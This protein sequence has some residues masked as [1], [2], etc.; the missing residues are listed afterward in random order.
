MEVIV[1]EVGLRDGLQNEAPIPLSDKIVLARS[2][3]GTGLR[4]IE[5]TAFMR[6]DAI[7]ALADADQMWE[8]CSAIP[9]VEW[10]ALVAN[11][12]GTQRALQAGATHLEFVVSASETHNR[13][14]VRRSRSE[15]LAEL[16]VV[17]DHVHAVGGDVQAIIATSFGCPYE[18]DI[19]LDEVLRTAAAARAA[20]ADSLAF[21]D[22]TGVATP[23]RVHQLVD[24]VLVDHAD[25]PLLMHFHDTRGLGIAN[26]LAALE[27]GIAR[28]DASVGGLGGCP[29]APG[30]SGNVAT[31][32]VVHVLH[33]MGID[34]GI[35]LEAI[36]S[37]AVLAE[38]MIGRKLPS[39]VM[40]AGPRTRR[41][42]V[43]DE[44][45]VQ[46]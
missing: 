5:A 7:P 46:G 10:S 43:P 33:D 16:E 22:T 30:A 11:V 26:L 36:I 20:G 28:F 39:H 15:S 42:E 31:E 14:N 25:L 29:Y 18:G 44:A 6:A 9:D 3:V 4:H 38:R 1:R 23:R 40:Q 27:M 21:G 13:A 35:D 2:L 34:T 37:T 24:A 12:T 19:P 41:A 8:F 45:G 32:E 17:A